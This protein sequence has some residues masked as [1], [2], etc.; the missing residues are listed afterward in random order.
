MKV[1][2]FLEVRPID[3]SLS[4]DDQVRCVR[5]QGVTELR[6]RHEIQVVLGEANDRASKLSPSSVAGYNEVAC[7][8]SVLTT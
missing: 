7:E 4:Q 6:V 2:G 5:H 3:L 8:L 1:K